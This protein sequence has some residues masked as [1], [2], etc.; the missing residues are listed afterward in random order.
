LGNGNSSKLEISS[1]DLIEI[2]VVTT[3]VFVGGTPKQLMALHRKRKAWLTRNP[4]APHS[5][6]RF[7]EP[8]VSADYADYT[9]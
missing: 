3:W 1:E 8:D 2:A 5:D 4:A 9:D 7:L 6:A